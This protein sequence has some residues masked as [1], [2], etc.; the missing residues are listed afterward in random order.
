MRSPYTLCR[1]CKQPMEGI[2][3]NHIREVCQPCG[4]SSLMTESY[5]EERRRVNNILKPKPQTQTKG[6]PL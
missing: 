1:R 4:G 5:E 6:E 3:T 2:L